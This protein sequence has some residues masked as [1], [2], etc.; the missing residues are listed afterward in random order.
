MKTKNSNTLHN[1]WISCW[2]WPTD[3]WKM[4]LYIRHNIHASCFSCGNYKAGMGLQP[5][6]VFSDFHLSWDGEIGEKHHQLLRNKQFWK[7]D[8]SLSLSKVLIFYNKN[9]HLD[10]NLSFREFI[11]NNKNKVDTAYSLR[12]LSNLSTKI[13]TQ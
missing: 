8:V 6:Q 7:Y 2:N 1:Y 3:K 5:W 11:Y 9:K 10:T 4:F 13:L 12:N